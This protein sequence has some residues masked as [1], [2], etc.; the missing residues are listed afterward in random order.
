MKKSFIQFVSVISVLV[1]LVS[2][3]SEKANDATDEMK[4]EVKTDH[5]YEYANID[6]VYQLINPISNITSSVTKIDGEKVNNNYTDS[7]EDIPNQ[8]KGEYNTFEITDINENKIIL[9]NNV[10]SAN[11]NY[12]IKLNWK[13]L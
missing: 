10:Y 5:Y 6:G 2:C 1:V 11:D 9:L 13:V 7:T 12:N 4:M 3:S 8:E